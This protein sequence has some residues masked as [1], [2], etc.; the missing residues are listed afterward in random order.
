MG[1]QSTDCSSLPMP[2]HAMPFS[3]ALRSITAPPP[4]SPCLL[5]PTGPPPSHP[6]AALRLALDSL[7]QFF[8][9]RSIKTHLPFLTPHLSG[10]SQV[11]FFSKCCSTFPE[12]LFSTFPI[13]LDLLLLAVAPLYCG[14]IY[15]YCFPVH[16]HNDQA[17]TDHT[18][19]YQTRPDRI[20]EP[21]LRLE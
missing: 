21:R 3:S 6:I 9:V 11:N 20:D 4:P 8:L 2:S 5:P 19:P 12:S 7:D 15:C 14:F 16:G 10:V 1:L 17:E 18:R 13:F